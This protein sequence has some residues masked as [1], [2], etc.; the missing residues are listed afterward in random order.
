[1]AKK[2]IQ[3]QSVKTLLLVPLDQAKERVYRQL[4]KGK[5]ILNI[6]IKN[7]EELRQAKAKHSSWHGYT[8]ELLK[9][10]SNT[11][12]IARKFAGGFAAVAVWART[13]P[14]HEEIN[15]FRKIVQR[16]LER[17]ASV[18]DQLELF[19]AAPP[20]APKEEESA[21]HATSSRSE[22]VTINNYGTI[23]NPQ[24]QQ[25]TTNSSQEITGTQADIAALLD[26]LTEAVE[27]MSLTLPE[28]VA[29]QVR[30]DLLVLVGEAR[31]NAARK[32][33]WQLSADGLKKAATDIGEIG[34]PVIELVSKIM[35]LLIAISNAK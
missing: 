28:E 32:E 2:T 17:L 19:P 20:E 25:G 23:Y 14:L 6:E 7:E 3:P 26:Q 18:Y 15:D 10:L 34:K 33:W 27:K 30:Q 22:R 1:M 21:S 29:R 13:P 16:N 8:E 9:Q 5:E 11:D 4:D 12:Q 24:I 35:P 31:S